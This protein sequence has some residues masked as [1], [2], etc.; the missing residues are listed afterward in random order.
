[1]TQEDT[2][3]YAAAFFVADH[4]VVESG[5]VYVNGAFWDRLRFPSFPM[6]FSFA[7]VAV[8]HVPWRAHHQRHNF[9]IHFMDADAKPLAARVEGGFQVGAA[10]EMAVGDPSILPFAA[11]VGNFVFERA[12]TYTAVL[13]VDGTE[14]ARWPMRADQALQASLPSGPGPMDAP[15]LLPSE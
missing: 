6:V 12:G 9:V 2:D 13:E 3:L 11:V 7:V 10:A 5:K 15:P 4:A 1:M 8:L 14:I